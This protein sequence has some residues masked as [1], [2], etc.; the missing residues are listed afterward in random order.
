MKIVGVLQGEMGKLEGYFKFI[1]GNNF[2]N[3]NLKYVLV[4]I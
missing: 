1:F 3:P 2:F 4:Q